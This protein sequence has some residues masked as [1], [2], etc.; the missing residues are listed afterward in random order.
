MP[1]RSVTVQVLG[2]VAWLLA[3]AAAAALGAIASAD[4]AD[5]YRQ[6]L[7]PDWAPPARLFG[8]V[9]SLLY[10]LMAVAA[11]LVWRAQGFRGAGPTLILY[12]VQLAVN[13]LWTW[14][15]FVWRLGGA[16]LIEILL[17]W[18]LIV[19]TIVAFW[20]FQRLAAVLLVPYLAW[21]SL[22][23]A[24]TFTTWQLNPSLLS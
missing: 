18:V 13:A 12:V 5:F 2:L 15:F 3:T 14:L 10:L 22:A 8:P 21:V 16:A 1:R 9:W 24:L 11:W 4:A 7:R 23:C 19:A 6:L 17:L 20:R